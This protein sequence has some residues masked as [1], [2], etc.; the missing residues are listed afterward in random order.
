VHIKQSST[1]DVP[2]PFLNRFDK[3]VKII[4]DA[5]TQV[6]KI[7]SLLGA[8]GIC[9]WIN[10]QTLDSIF[11]DMLPQNCTHASAN[12]LP[13]T[14]IGIISSF[15]DCVIEF[16]RHFTSLAVSQKDLNLILKKA[17]QCLSMEDSTVLESLMGP[18]PQI[19]DA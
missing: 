1:E 9:G 14:H 19:K 6:A 16:I 3:L 17:L 13:Q 11:V 18:S 4:I 12:F 7:C 5:R 8:N 2:A 15:T 10:L